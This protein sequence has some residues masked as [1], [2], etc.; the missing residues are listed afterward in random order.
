[1]SDGVA[2]LRHAIAHPETPHASSR[3]VPFIR[4]SFIVLGDRVTVHRAD[5]ERLEHEHGER[6]RQELGT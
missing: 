2:R 4:T 6:A 3:S 5:G 1:M